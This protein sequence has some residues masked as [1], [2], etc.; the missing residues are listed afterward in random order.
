MLL[1]ISQHNTTELTLQR[2]RKLR[3]YT[4]PSLTAHSVNV[5]NHHMPTQVYLGLTV[6]AE[7]FSPPFTDFQ[8]AIHGK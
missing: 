8:K 7:E 1:W 5:I 6:Q 2:L 4:L 3:V